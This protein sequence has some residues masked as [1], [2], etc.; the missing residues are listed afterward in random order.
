MKQELEKELDSMWKEKVEAEHTQEDTDT[1]IPAKE[2][3]LDPP[4]ALIHFE[5]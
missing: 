2:M 1:F 5:L 3:K 4:N